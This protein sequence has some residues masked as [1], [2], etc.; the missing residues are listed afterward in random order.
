MKTQKHLPG[1]QDGEED[2]E[3]IEITIPAGCSGPHVKTDFLLF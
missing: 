1:V 2:K 3:T